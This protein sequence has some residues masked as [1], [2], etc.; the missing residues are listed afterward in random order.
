MVKRKVG[1]AWY[2]PM[3]WFNQTPAGYA[4]L[5]AGPVATTGSSWF[6]KNFNNIV[7][8]VFMV[9]FISTIFGVI[10]WV[11]TKEK[12]NKPDQGGGT[13]PSGGAVDPG[14]SNRP[15][16]VDIAAINQ[17]PSAGQAIIYFSKAEAA[18]TT[19]DSCEVEF[20]TTMTYTGAYP[21]NPD[22]V[23]NVTTV[24]LSAGIVNI[25]YASQNPRGSDSLP[26]QVQIDVTA[27][28]I[29]PITGVRGGPVSKSTQLPYIG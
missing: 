16:R 9:V 4:A 11:I 21:S 29:N 2:N 15:G 24:P 17:G 28:V 1:G 8:G 20:K 19:C 23:T 3:T 22:P 12:K 18:G 27:T 13:T 25:S 6:S 26:T 10:I 5:P 14:M 7:L